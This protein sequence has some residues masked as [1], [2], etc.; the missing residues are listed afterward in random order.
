MIKSGN[1]ELH[2]GA[3]SYAEKIE[4]PLFSLRIS[5]F[6]FDTKD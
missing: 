5:V 6:L 1:M 4:T 2:G 3:R